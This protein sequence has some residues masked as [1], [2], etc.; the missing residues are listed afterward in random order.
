MALRTVGG[1][2]LNL[3]RT[4]ANIEET[5]QD[6]IKVGHI[7]RA[8]TSS[9]YCVNSTANN[10]TPTRYPLGRVVSIEKGSKVCT[11]EWFN[12]FA[13]VTQKYSTVGTLGSNVIMANDKSTIT[14]SATIAAQDNTYIWGIDTGNTTM[15]FLVM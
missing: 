13:V 10:T 9:N 6:T 12:V 5:H 4:A 1:G 8:G 11:V 3:L 15:T 2:D 7:V 14:G